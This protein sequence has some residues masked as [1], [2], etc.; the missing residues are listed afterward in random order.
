M[1]IGWDSVENL[2][3]PKGMHEIQTG[4]YFRANTMMKS[5][6]YPVISTTENVEQKIPSVKT[7][8]VLLDTIDRVFM[9]REGEYVWNFLN[10]N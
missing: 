2:V 6:E 3:L 4:S 9:D 10:K 8:Y 5:Y 7:F 1:F